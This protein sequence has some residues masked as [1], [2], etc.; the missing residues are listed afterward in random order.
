MHPVPVVDGRWSFEWTFSALLDQA[1]FGLVTQDG[2]GN[3]TRSPMIH[4]RFVGIDPPPVALA[5]HPGLSVECR[6]EPALEAERCRAWATVTLERHPELLVGATRVL[7]ALPD[8]FDNCSAE[9]RGADGF[10]LIGLVVPC[11]KEGL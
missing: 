11:P 10:T 6:G 4:V 9:S 3:T 7:L 8:R 1:A 2:A 5:E